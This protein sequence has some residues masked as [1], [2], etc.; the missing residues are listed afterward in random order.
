MLDAFCI[1]FSHCFF[2]VL[3]TVGCVMAMVLLFSFSLLSSQYRFITFSRSGIYRCSFAVKSIKV[4][5]AIVNAYINYPSDSV[6]A[7]QPP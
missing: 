7:S 3:Q 5:T 1:A 6:S 2:D 4:S